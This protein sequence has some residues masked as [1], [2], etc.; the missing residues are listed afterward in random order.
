MVRAGGGAGEMAASASLF[1]VALI[2]LTFLDHGACLVL[3]HQAQAAAL[4][5]PPVSQNALGLLPH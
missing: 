4:H 1:P 3:A 5:S 2:P